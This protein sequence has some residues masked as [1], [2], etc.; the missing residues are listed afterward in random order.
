M[1]EQTSSGNPEADFRSVAEAAEA[2]GVSRQTLYR[3]IAA[4]KVPTPSHVRG[5]D[6][7]QM[8]T[9]SEFEEVRRVAHGVER[10]FAVEKAQMP[11]FGDKPS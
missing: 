2:I 7:R 6:G 4:G 10:R 8:F 5:R 3:W 11:L 1:N 9:E